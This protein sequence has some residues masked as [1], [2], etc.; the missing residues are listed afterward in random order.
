MKKGTILHN[1]W[2]SDEN[3]TRYFIYT[4]IN[5]KYATGITFNGKDLEK[6]KYH[7]KEFED[8]F[9]ING[10][11]V[12]VGYCKAFDI[13]REDLLKFLKGEAE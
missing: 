11:L 12:A 13:M 10:Q 9:K 5:E 1:R 8:D 2:A 7:R 6:I 3:P 4:G